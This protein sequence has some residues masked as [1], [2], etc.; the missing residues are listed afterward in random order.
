MNHGFFT[1]FRYF[2]KSA[3]T[4]MGRE[5]WKQGVQSP[6]QC[7]L[8][9]PTAPLG[10]PGSAPYIT[11]KYGVTQHFQHLRGSHATAIISAT[12]QPPTSAAKFHSM[13]LHKDGIYRIHTLPFSLLSLATFYASP[14]G[15]PHNLGNTRVTYIQST[16]LLLHL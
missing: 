13:F 5:G 2:K 4:G 3:H 1:C 12:L 11:N 15:V 10:P 6:V 7:G 14:S 8:L 16:R 9:A